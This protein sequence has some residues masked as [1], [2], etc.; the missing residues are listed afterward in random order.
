MFDR[1][2]RA[3]QSSTESV[4]DSDSAHAAVPVTDQLSDAQLL[5][6]WQTQ[7]LDGRRVDIL[8]PPREASSSA[9]ILFLHGH[10]R[11]MLDQNP[12]YTR[13]C[14][15]AGLAVVC[16]DGGQSWWLHEH[17]PD[18]SATTTDY[19]GT[20]QEWLLN[21]VIPLM[22]A[23][24]GVQPPNIALMGVSMGG[25]GILQ[26]AYRHAAQYP[27]LAAIAPAVDFHQMYGSGIPLDGIFPDV[28]AARQATVILNLHPLSWPRYQFF[29]CDPTDTE[30][31]DG[32]ARLGMKLSSSGILHERDL[33]TSHGGHTWDY[34]N[35]MAPRVLQHLQHGLANVAGE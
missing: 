8:R 3:L 28:E 2:R 9:A 12:V 15:D 33:E 7:Y 34:F 24:L 18:F 5:A 13:L 16:P 31:F 23:E 22:H 6:L 14:C 20:P 32:V 4:Q 27:V 29:C 19:S 17:C 35:H 30:W 1:L 26:L 10:G 25:Q 11:V 21:R